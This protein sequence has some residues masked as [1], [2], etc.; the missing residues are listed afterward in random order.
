MKRFSKSRRRFCQFNDLKPPHKRL[1]FSPYAWLKLLYFLQAGDTEVGGFGLSD[2][3]NP[4]YV[5][6]VLTVRQSVTSVHV[7][8]DD[9]AVADHFDHCLDLGIPPS[10]CGRIW[11]HTHPGSDPDPSLLDERTFARVFGSCDWA[12]MFILSRT[13]RTYAR[14]SFGAGPGGE[15]PLEVAVDWAA[16]PQIVRQDEGQ[17]IESLRNWADEYA[18][19]V[20]PLPIAKPE[21]L[22]NPQ[23][24]LLQVSEASA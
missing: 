2:S 18:L 12:V 22:F 11:W 13:Q 7:S 16:W 20:H 10:R 6:D 17:W 23:Q 9:D 8:F 19:N 15:M 3:L 1:V 5:Q 21:D 24:D 14:L 4:L